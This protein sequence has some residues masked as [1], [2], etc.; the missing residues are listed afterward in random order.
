MDLSI[1]TSFTYYLFI[2]VCLRTILVICR[3]RQSVFTLLMYGMYADQLTWITMWNRPESTKQQTHQTTITDCNT[4]TPFSFFFAFCLQYYNNVRK[5][6]RNALT[7]VFQYTCCLCNISSV[8]FL[9][10]HASSLKTNGTLYSLWN[11][12]NKPHQPDATLKS[13]YI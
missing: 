5:G 4:H 10:F 6:M 2:W 13:I 12:L 9:H 3:S 8:F 1:S 11:I 7:L